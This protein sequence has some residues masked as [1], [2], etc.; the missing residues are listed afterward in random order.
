MFCTDELPTSCTPS[1][2]LARSRA[3]LQ[4]PDYIT[5]SPPVPWLYHVLPS[6]SLAVSRT[7]SSQ[8]V[9]RATLQFPK[10]IT[11]PHIPFGDTW[12]GKLSLSLFSSFTLIVATSPLNTYDFFYLSKLGKKWLSYE[13]NTMSIFGHTH[14]I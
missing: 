14:Q 4:F 10:F 1:S 9:S 2:S 11:C 3:P 12:S 7:P 8:T 13:Q 5:C 6:S